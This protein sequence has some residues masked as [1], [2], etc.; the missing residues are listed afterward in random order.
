MALFFIDEQMMYK[1]SSKFL[2]VMI[3]DY[4]FDPIGGHEAEII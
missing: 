4:I 2:C 3:L 1:C